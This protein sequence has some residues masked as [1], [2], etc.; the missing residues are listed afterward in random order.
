MKKRVCVVYIGPDDRVTV[1]IDDSLSNA[2]LET[3]IG[4]MIVCALDRG[5][6]A[7]RVLASTRYRSL[8]TVTPLQGDPCAGTFD[9]RN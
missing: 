5:C 6:D 9:I 3:L 2:E 8:N 4:S 1:D 7:G